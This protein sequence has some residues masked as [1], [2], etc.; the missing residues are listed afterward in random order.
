ML[1]LKKYEPMKHILIFAAQALSLDG[2]S[3]KQNKTVPGVF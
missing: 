2:C 3:Q 1:F